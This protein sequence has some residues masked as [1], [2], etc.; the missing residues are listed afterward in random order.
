MYRSVDDI[1]KWARTTK[2]PRPLILC[3][4]SHAMGNSNGSLSDYYAAFEREHGLQGGF[5]WEWVD[6]GLRQP[7]DRGG[8][9]WAYGGD[10][11]DKPNDE[12]FCCD[13][14]VWPDRTPHPGLFE[15]KHLARPVS[16]EPL[17]LSRGSVRIRNKRDFT[18]LEDLRGSFRV[19][20]DGR[21]VQRGKLPRLRTAAHQSTDV[22]LAL[23]PAKL[24]AGEEAFLVVR[25]ELER[26]SAF[27][28]KGHLVAEDTLALPWRTPKLKAL[29]A[30]TEARVERDGNRIQLAVAA[31]AATFDGETGALLSLER[32]GGKQILDGPRLSLWRAPTDN[33]ARTFLHLQEPGAVKWADLGLDKL[34]VVTSRVALRE[35][36]GAPPTLSVAQTL[37]IP[38]SGASVAFE[39]RYRLLASGALWMDHTVRIDPQLKDLPRVGVVLSLDPALEHLAWLGRGPLESYCDR[40]AAAAVGRYASTVTGQTVPYIRP[41]AHGN[42]TETRWMALRDAA[43]AGLLVTAPAPFDFT[44]LHFTEEDLARTRHAHELVARPEVILHL[45]AKHRGV[46]TGSCGPDALPRY[47]IKPGLH[48]FTFVLRPFGAEEEPARLARSGG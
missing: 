8:W 14:L 38:A 2:D 45:D 22:K 5:I 23:R 29:R 47:R 36:R 24:A 9:H 26:A 11:G 46:G 30:P 18:T 17:N 15:F 32:Q 13:G 28:P 16:V 6:H 42:H 27:A 35:R 41:Q 19:E 1:V 40:H 48:R 44:A 7:D 33:D 31:T 37:R 25:F 39:R 4:Y 34:E 21:V 3:E 12:N 10:F 43:G 20:V